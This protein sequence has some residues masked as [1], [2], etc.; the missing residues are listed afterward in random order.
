MLMPHRGPERELAEHQ[1]CRHQQETAD[2]I[3]HGEELSGCVQLFPPPAG[4][5]CDATDEH[6]KTLRQR[7][8]EDAQPIG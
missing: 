6:Q 7:A 1:E 4:D 5:Q 3:R 8:V 2:F